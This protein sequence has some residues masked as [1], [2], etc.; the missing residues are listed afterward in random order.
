MPKRQSHVEVSLFVA[1]VISFNVYSS[2]MKLR[3]MIAIG[4]VLLSIVGVAVVMAAEVI[5]LEEVD[6]AYGTG[7]CC[8]GGLL[9]ACVVATV[10]MFYLKKKRI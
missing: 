5:P 7:C 8:A 4:F 1:N 6:P 10:F 9:I 3:M 2:F